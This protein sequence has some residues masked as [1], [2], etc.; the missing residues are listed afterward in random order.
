M[1]YYL[2]LFSPE[3][4]EAFS[5]SDRQISGFRPRHRSSAMGVKPADRFICYMTPVSRWVGVLEVKR[6]PFEDDTPIFYEQ[7]DPFTLRFE[8]QSIAWLEKD[9]TIPIHVEEV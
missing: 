6:G 8:V 7:N 2:C 1:A 4:Y 9:K 5:S 3:T